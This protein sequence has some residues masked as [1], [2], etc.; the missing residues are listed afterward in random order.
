MAARV[1][2]SIRAL[3]PAKAGWAP[4]EGE[5]AALGEE[6][7][8]GEESGRVVTVADPLGLGCC[9]PSFSP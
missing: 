9:A 6:E 3:A 7:A 2:A 4:D 8:D 1:V 5:A